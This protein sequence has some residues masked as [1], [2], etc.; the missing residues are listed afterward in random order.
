MMTFELMALLV[1]V[2]VTV[3]VLSELVA[4]MMV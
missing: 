1:Q 3:L 2:V 4:L